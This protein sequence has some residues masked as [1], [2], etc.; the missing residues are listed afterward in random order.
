MGYN[1]DQGKKEEVLM[2]KSFK[3]IVVGTVV[4]FIAFFSFNRVPIEIIKK[5]S[6]WRKSFKQ[7]LVKGNSFKHSGYDV[8]TS[9]SIRVDS[10][11]RS[12][13]KS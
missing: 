9:A 3:Y 2:R 12:D 6:F 10:F 5:F 7:V 13:K 8:I 1:L 4:S 11:S